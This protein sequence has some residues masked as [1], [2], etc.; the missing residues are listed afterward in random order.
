M[1]NAQKSRYDKENHEQQKDTK[2]KGKP[3]VSAVAVISPIPTASLVQPSRDA[4]TIDIGHPFTSSQPSYLPLSVTPRISF[5]LSLQPNTT[6]SHTKRVLTRSCYWNGTG[7]SMS[8]NQVKL[9]A[10]TCPVSVDCADTVL[11]FLHSTLAD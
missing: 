5:D 1:W 10:M 11:T 8:V 4:M 2:F 3:R 6:T 9:P 7:V